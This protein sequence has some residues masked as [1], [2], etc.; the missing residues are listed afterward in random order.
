MK[1]WGGRTL[2]RFLAG[3]GAGLLDLLGD[4]VA[5]IPGRCVR[6][7]VLGVVGGGRWGGGRK[8]GMGVRVE[9]GQEEIGKRVGG[10]GDGEGEGSGYYLM[11]CMLRVLGLEIWKRMLLT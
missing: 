7:G 8:E 10:R 4:L 9:E 6:G 5:E 2:V 11:D 3:R 1:G